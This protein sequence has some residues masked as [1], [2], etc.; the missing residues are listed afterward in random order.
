MWFEPLRSHAF[1]P[2]DKKSYSH[3]FTSLRWKWIYGSIAFVSEKLISVKQ[4]AISL[5]CPLLL[6]TSTYIQFLQS[7]MIM[8]SPLKSHIFATNSLSRQVIHNHLLN[9]HIAAWIFRPVSTHLK[10]IRLKG[11]C[12]Y[13]NEMRLTSISCSL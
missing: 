8:V 2:L 9:V 5:L 12:W 1:S 6:K 3:C 11:F 13:R 4:T 7:V 10:T